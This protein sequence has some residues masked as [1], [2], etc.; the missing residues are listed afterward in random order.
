MLRSAALRG[1]MM[2]VA[3]VQQLPKNPSRRLSSFPY[4][5]LAYLTSS[6]GTFIPDRLPAIELDTSNSD[7]SSH[8][9]SASYGDHCL[10]PSISHA[11]TA[12]CC[13]LYQHTRDEPW[14][15]RCN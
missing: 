5:T 10:V 6:L 13:H 15:W 7:S 3:I 1:R 11:Y 8:G 12:G 4:E 2:F 9:Y 14:H